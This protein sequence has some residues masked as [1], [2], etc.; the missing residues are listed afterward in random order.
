MHFEINIAKNGSHFFATAERSI[1][2]ESHLARVYTELA[3][4]FTREKGFCISVSRHQ[5]YT[6]T[7]ISLEDSMLKIKE[8]K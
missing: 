8:G 2:S 4:S 7:G 1:T 5:T 6:G 3:Q